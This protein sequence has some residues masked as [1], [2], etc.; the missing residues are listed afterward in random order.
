MKFKCCNRQMQFDTS[1]KSILQTLLMLVLGIILYY[2]LPSSLKETGEKAM[3][4]I[5]NEAEDEAQCEMERVY[6]SPVQINPLIAEMNT[7][8]MNFIRNCVSFSFLVIN[9]YS[10]VVA[11]IKGPKN[12]ILFTLATTML[13]LGFFLI[14]KLEF[15]QF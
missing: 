12:V 14:D 1:V 3:R 7:R 2:I 8:Q 6:N 10:L 5:Q 15:F 4:N 11:L 13:S 9:S